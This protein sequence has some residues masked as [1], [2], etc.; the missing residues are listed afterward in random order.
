VID[1]ALPTPRE[2]GFEREVLECPKASSSGSA[3]RR[4]TASSPQPPAALI[5]FVHYSEI[6]GGGYRSLNDSPG[7]L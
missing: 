3:T 5:I 6:S 7:Q 1:S 4:G 2:D